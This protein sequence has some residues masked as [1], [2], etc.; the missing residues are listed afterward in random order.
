MKSTCILKTCM[1]ESFDTS[2][3]N[4][5]QLCSRPLADFQAKIIII[6][7]LGQFHISWITDILLSQIPTFCD[8]THFQM[9]FKFF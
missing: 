4:L 7:L 9:L 3:F 1:V 2:H 5:E 8:R 6:A